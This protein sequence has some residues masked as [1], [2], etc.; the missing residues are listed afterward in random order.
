MST[1]TLVAKGGEE[2]QVNSEVAQLSKLVKD[3]LEGDE[4][5][6]AIE[7]G[8]IEKC[9]LEKVV[10]FMTHLHSQPGHALPTIPA[11]IT[12]DKFEDA[13]GD[14]WSVQ[15]VEDLTKNDLFA[16]AL[17]ANKLDCKP[18]LDLTS[19][20]LAF[21]CKDKDINGLREVFQ[22]ENDFTPEEEAQVAEE[23]KT[24]HEIL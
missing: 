11:P 17:A 18:L 2:V 9:H 1:V 20:R 6:E 15:F 21:E 8:D 5:E 4:G 10:A 13:I 14:Q 3:A 16:V 22:I 19:A 7:L 23:I 24:A 12:A